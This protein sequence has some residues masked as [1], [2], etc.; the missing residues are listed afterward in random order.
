M[1]TQLPKFFIFCLYASQAT[2]SVRAKAQRRI[3]D[4]KLKNDGD[5]HLFNNTRRVKSVGPSL[6]E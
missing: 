4:E 3:R 2:T 5:R 1:N 6:I